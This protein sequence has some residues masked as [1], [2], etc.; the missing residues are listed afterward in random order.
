[1]N[2]RQSDNTFSSYRDPINILLSALARQNATDLEALIVLPGADLE[3]ALAVLYGSGVMAALRDVLTAA[4][5]ELLA[6]KPKARSGAALAGI[7][8]KRLALTQN[9]PGRRAVPVERKSDPTLIGRLRQKHLLEG[10]HALIA[11]DF[12]AIDPAI[13]DASCEMR[14]FFLLDLRERVLRA[15]DVMGVR[16]P[17]A[18]RLIAAYRAR[19][20]DDP[21]ETAIIAADDLTTDP[22]AA[23]DMALWRRLTGALSMPGD[24]VDAKVFLSL[25]R[26]YS[27]A[28]SLQ[29][30]EF[31]LPVSSRMRRK[32]PLSADPWGLEMLGRMTVDLMAWAA[33]DIVRRR[34]TAATEAAA[35][36]L[37]KPRAFK[38]M[39]GARLPLLPI[40]EAMRTILAYECLAGRPL[41]LSLIRLGRRWSGTEHQFDFM[42]ASPMLLI[43]ATDGRYVTPGDLTPFMRQPGY[44]YRCFSV[45]DLDAPRVGLLDPALTMAD[46]KRR[47]AAGDVVAHLLAYAAV[48]PPFADGAEVSKRAM[49]SLRLIPKRHGVKELRLP[50]SLF[51]TET[52]PMEEI[53]ALRAHAEGRGA[54]DVRYSVRMGRDAVRRLDATLD[55]A[56][57]HIH[58]G[59]MVGE[60]A[61]LSR[62]SSVMTGA[63]VGERYDLKAKRSDNVIFHP[64]TT[65]TDAEI[66]RLVRRA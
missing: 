14:P 11:G 7:V 1:M 66:M 4:G 61:R 60:I 38:D 42:G 16:L 59:T 13:G 25:C 65:T 2:S 58:A 33:A 53:A 56:P 10:V 54:V 28:T 31:L 37:S 63:A 17:T 30:D 24:P 57:I 43:P 34:P 40:Y 12:D 22:E 5:G 35:A 50:L 45:I 41:I 29:L 55:F 49:G 21:D 48:H 39:E 36:V 27:L 44:V 3:Q 26:G 8:R 19:H 62:L 52:E 64:A 6:L 32:H 9:A 18:L 51:A 46:V 20:A 47:M 15:L 23:E